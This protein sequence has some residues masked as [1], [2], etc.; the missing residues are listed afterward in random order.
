VATGNVDGVGGR[1]EGRWGKEREITKIYRR[2]TWP[3]WQGA[4]GT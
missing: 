1:G 3:E 4:V 2:N